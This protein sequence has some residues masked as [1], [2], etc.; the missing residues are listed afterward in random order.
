MQS[1]VQDLMYGLRG[2][3]RQPAFAALAILALALGI[4]SA[5]TIFSVIQNVLLDPFPYMD[6]HRVVQFQIRDVTR[7]RPGGRTMYQVPEFLD[8]K[9]QVTSFED[10]IAGGFEDVLLTTGEGA[11]QFNGGQVSGNMFQFLGVPALAGRILTPDDAKPGA[12][13]VFV[14]SYK[15]WV[16]HFNL[17]PS[18]L[19]R[20]FTLNGVATTL[21]GIMPKRFTKLNADLYRPV[22]LDRA[23]PETNRRFYMF[24][25]RLKPGRTLDDAEAELNVVSQRL[26]KI[27]PDNYPK[28]F[29]VKAVSWVEAIVGPFRKTLYTLAAAVGLLLLIACANVANMLLARAP[30]REK[31]MAIRASLGAT[32]PRLIRQLLVESVLLAVIA[33]VFGCAIAYFGIKGL[34]AAIPDGFIP[35]EAAIRLNVPVLL[36]SLAMALVTSVVFALVPALHAARPDLVEPLR[37][38]GK[39]LGGGSRRGRLT[40]ALVVAEVALSLVLL[41]GAGLLMRTFIKLQTVDLGFDPEN[42]LAARIPLPKGQYQT[43]SEKQQLFSQLLARV[44]ALP[45]VVAAAAVSSLPPY[46]GIRT[47]IDILGQAQTEKRQSL[48]QLVSEG[49]LSTLGMRVQRGRWLTDTDVSGARKVAVVNQLFVEKFLAGEDP[50]GRQVKLKNLATI[51]D[52]KVDDPTFEI[53]GVV[54]DLKNQGLQ[55]PAIPEAFIPYTITGAFERG[56]LLRTKGKPELLVNSLRRELWAIDRNVA[57]TLPGSLTSFMR[58]YSFAEP[59]FGLAVLGVFAVV[60]LVLVA[61]G[62]FSVIAYTVSRQTREIG[63]RMAMGADWTDVLRMVLHMAARPLGLGLVIGLAVSLAVTRVLA[64]QLWQVSPYDPLTLLLVV[65]IVGLVGLLACAFPALRATRVQPMQALRYE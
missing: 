51:P 59:R 34:V 14:M 2:L 8:Y 50:I 21:V 49:Y 37:D 54:A 43:A 57:L 25:G 64:N 53:V 42:I 41:A 20:S 3:R 36:F 32:R 33:A 28:K 62:V 9:E 46:G 55:D 1:I 56:L 45:G 26:A 23:D 44:H 29:T 7:T 35:H 30:A 40:S 61:L 6:A 27:Y 52:A 65:A 58:Q 11:E 5:T 13:P 19:G 10:V 18:I 12:P 15:M 48:Y 24:Q 22:I 16:K 63:I 60:G 39:G 4:G 38:A 31:E 17:D 47:D